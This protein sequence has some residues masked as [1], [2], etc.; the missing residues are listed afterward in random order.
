MT[1]LLKI[2]LVR[3]KADREVGVLVVS[4]LWPENSELGKYQKRDWD[5]V[6]E[7][8]FYSETKVPAKS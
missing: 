3:R 6:Q 5:D 1:H 2:A 7:I 4:K 8:E